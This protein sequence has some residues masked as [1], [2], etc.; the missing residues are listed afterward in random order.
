MLSNKTDLVGFVL[1]FKWFFQKTKPKGLVGPNP[2][3]PAGPGP[4][5]R[6]GLAWLGSRPWPDPTRRTRSPSRPLRLT[7]ASPRAPPGRPHVAAVIPAVPGPLRHR[8]G[9]VLLLLDMIY[10]PLLLDLIPAASPA[11][12]RPRNPMYWRPT[13]SPPAYPGRSACWC[14]A[15]P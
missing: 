1:F 6:V 12:S 13:W 2:T 8:C 11:R 5:D 7:L 15:A 4:T 9:G 3:D 14:C 10:L